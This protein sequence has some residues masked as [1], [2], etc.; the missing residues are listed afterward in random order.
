MVRIGTSK[1]TGMSKLPWLT[2]SHGTPYVTHCN[3]PDCITF[4]AKWNESA[5]PHLLPFW[6][7]SG[8]N[9]VGKTPKQHPCLA[10]SHLQQPEYAHKDDPTGVYAMKQR[11]GSMGRQHIVLELLGTPTTPDFR[12]FSAA[13][14]NMKV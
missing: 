14:Y 4:P 6:H 2:W 3:Q 7:V 5:S 9:R 10:V 8:Q 11:M 13:W 1:D 12:T